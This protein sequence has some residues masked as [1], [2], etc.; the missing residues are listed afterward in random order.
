MCTNYTPDIWWKAVLC[1]C[2]CV[3]TITGFGQRILFSEGYIVK[4]QGDTL[5]GKIR[6]STPALRSAKV[7]FK[8]EGYDERVVYRPF[9]I[10]GYFVEEQYYESRIYDI[11]PSLS[12]G[13]GV[14]MQRLNEDNAPVKLY[15]YWNTDRERG[16]TQTFLH[17]E[18]EPLL[19]IQVLKF[20]KQV[21]QFLKDCPEI[22]TSFL[23]GKYN[24]RHLRSIVD[25]YN[26][27][28]KNQL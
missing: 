1:L 5:Y 24:K 26:V 12:Y 13:L 21:A 11:H 15:Q 6:Y 14:F 16:F 2:F 17:R 25:K 18:G 28:K 7:I 4:F 19:E 3:I 10:K 20:K 22:N 27:W 9:Q 23:K 8:Q